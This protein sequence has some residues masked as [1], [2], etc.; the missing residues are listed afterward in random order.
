MD[1]YYG[2]SSQPQIN[3]CENVWGNVEKTNEMF[4][5]V[6]EYLSQQLSPQQC[7]VLYVQTL[8]LSVHISVSLKQWYPFV[9][10]HILKLGSRGLMLESRSCNRKVVSSSLSPA[11]FVGGGSECPALSP[12][13]IPRLS[14]PWAR[15]RTLNVYPE[16][17]PRCRSIGCPL[18][19]V[20]VHGVCVCVF[21]AVCVCALWMG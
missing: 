13:L 17:L 21:N 10:F 8:C 14:C 5:A 3:R 18:L 11:G 2:H 19:R 1:W 4:K 6:W 12:S 9:T 7:C 20:C 15:H 16:L